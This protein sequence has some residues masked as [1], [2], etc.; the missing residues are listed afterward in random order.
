MSP[1][2]ILYWSS[3]GILT[4]IMVFSVYNYF[5]N[6]EAIAGFFE[7]FLYPTYLIYPLAVA[8]ILGLLAI[9]GNFSELLKGLA[10]AGFFYNTLFAFFA[11]LITDGS[12]YL[13]SLM[14]LICVV[15]SYFTG[16]KARP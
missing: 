13:F 11:H 5:F 8:K 16:R 2:R 6:Y 1:N 10:Y 4:A 7:H 9:W 15:I 14:A 12:G 3:S